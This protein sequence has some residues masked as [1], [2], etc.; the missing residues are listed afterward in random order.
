MYKNL[1]AEMAKSV[2]TKRAMASTLGM[3]ENTLKNKL[4][5]KSAFTVE[6]S[7]KIKEIFFPN[8]EL[9][10]LFENDETLSQAEE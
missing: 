4:S 9:P 5:G 6:E 1:I 8:Q 7:F 3:H 2:V 10:Y